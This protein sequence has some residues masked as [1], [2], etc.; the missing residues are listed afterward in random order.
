MARRRDEIKE[1]QERIKALPPKD[2]AEVVKGVLTPAMQL[3][4]TLG[5]IW[6]KQRKVNLRGIDRDIRAVRREAEREHA[7]RRAGRE[8]K[9]AP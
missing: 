4:L 6:K 1:L 8:R 5:R 7:A 3:G 2:Q 9:R